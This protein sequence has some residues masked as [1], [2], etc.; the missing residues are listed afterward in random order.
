MTPDTTK[1]TATEAYNKAFAE[2]CYA[3]FNLF[4]AI[5]VQK[6]DYK[7]TVDA[8]MNALQLRLLNR[9]IQSTLSKLP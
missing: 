2:W 7:A 4:R 6:R 3:T 5:G 8:M 9:K 1:A